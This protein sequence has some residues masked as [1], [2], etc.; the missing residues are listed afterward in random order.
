VSQSGKRI[1]V[2]DDERPLVEI[3]VDQF[4]ATGYVVE[5]ATSGLD[6][7]RAIERARPDVVL[8]DIKM[9][10]MNGIEVLKTIME[11]DPSIVVIM[12]TGN[13]DL[14]LTVEALRNGAFGYVPKPFDF[15]Y[16]QHLIAVAAGA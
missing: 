10:N 15:R 7:I 16:L 5:T 6:A 13:T 11:L 3:V 8:L 14:S 9:P 1:L 2:V 4:A 12:M